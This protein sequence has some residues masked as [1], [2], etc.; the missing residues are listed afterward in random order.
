VAVT[1]PAKLQEKGIDITLLT[2]CGVLDDTPNAVKRVEVFNS[3]K[4]RMLSRILG[5]LRKPTLL[6]WVMMFVETVVTLLKALRMVGKGK[7]SLLHLRDGEPFIFLPFVLCMLRKNIRW[8]I[9]LTASVLYIPKIKLK[10]IRKS[11]FVVLYALALRVL[12][13]NSL[14]KVV[15]KLSLMRNSYLLMPQN[16]T[17]TKA[18]ERYLGGVFVK[19]VRCVELG[20]SDDAVIMNK[21]KARKRL[22]VPKKAFVALSFGAPHSGK[23]MET[24]FDALSHC[25]SVYLLHGGTHTYSTGSNPLYLAEKYNIQYRS[26][27]INRYIPEHEHSLFFSAS[28]VGL[29]SYTKAFAGTSSMLWELAKYRVPCISSDANSLGEDVYKY[30]LGSLFDAENAESLASVVERFRS[31]GVGETDKIKDNCS[32]FIDD[33]SADKWAEKC[34]SVYKELVE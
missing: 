17:A 29:L 19:H 7:Y 27:I 12:V 9:S 13:G 4:W 2:F 14:W 15:Y 34:I 24:I 25:P 10:D 33:H 26:K 21:L 31:L 30:G 1:E 23:D 3:K 8:A 22:G 32:K 5:K 28:D 6:R 18:Y 11:P 20:V 16:R